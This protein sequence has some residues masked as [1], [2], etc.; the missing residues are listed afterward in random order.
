M[1]LMSVSQAAQ[2]LGVSPRRV[3]AL[4]QS[5]RVPAVRVG[6]NWALDRNL[7][8]SQGRR[9]GGR[10]ISAD[11]AWALLALLSGSQA[12]WIDVFSRSR[13]KRRLPSRQWLEKA[14]QWSEPRA[15]VY[16]WRI[17]PSDLPKLEG[18]SL[19]STR[20]TRVRRTSGDSSRRIRVGYRLKT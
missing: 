7:L 14:L 2:A 16:S 12:P 6:R 8:R 13:L 11:N 10:P 20:L 1:N 17:L 9:R 18:Y 19:R 15:A 3:R 5:N 4:I